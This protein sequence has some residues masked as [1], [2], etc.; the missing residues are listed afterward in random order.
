[1]SSQQMLAS[2]DKLIPNSPDNCKQYGGTWVTVP[3]YGLAAPQCMLHPIARDNHLGNVVQTS[4]S[5]VPL[6]MSQP[7]PAYYDW[8]LPNDMAG[9]QCVIRIR[10]NVSNTNYPSMDTFQTDFTSPKD[11]ILTNSAYNCQ[12]NQ[13]QRMPND[14]RILNSTAAECQNILSAT[15]VPLFNRPYVQ[16]FDS[17]DPLLSLAINSDQNGRT[18]QD[19]TYVFNVSSKPVGGNI[20]NLNMKGKRGNIVQTYPAVEYGFV[21]KDLSVTTNDYV[22]VQFC[23]SDYNQPQDPNDGEGMRYSDRSNMVQTASSQTNFPL[24]SSQM[25]MF[26]DLTMAKM[27]AY[28]GMNISA[29]ACGYYFGD[30]D[31]DAN[32]QNQYNNCG[33]LNSAPQVF[34]APLVQFKN[35]GFFTYMSTRPNNFSNRSNKGTLSVSFAISTAG[36]VGI[37]FGIVAG[38]GGVGFGAV[39]FWARRHPTSSLAE[40]LKFGTTRL[41]STAVA[42]STSIAPGWA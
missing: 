14:S 3:S 32:A 31:I 13:I 42:P 35:P 33:K 20:Y 21:P 38:L 19:R 23:G 25:T 40:K 41:G 16:V 28:V 37:S 1:M 11:G 6:T 22:H 17:S 4:S 15:Q 26:N 9:K 24:P 30:N 36:W 2:E 7:A 27:F 12:Q 10:Y 34:N 18:F 5:G 39:F 29:G 8:T